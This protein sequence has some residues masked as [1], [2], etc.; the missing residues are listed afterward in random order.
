MRKIENLRELQLVNVFIYKELAEFCERNGLKVYL[1]GGS[2]IGAVRHKGFIPWDD[3]LDVC[4]SRKDYNKMLKISKGRISE[5]CSV[6]D[7]AK[8]K[9]FKGYISLVSYDKSKIVSKQYKQRENAKISVSVFVYDGVP[10][11]IAV[12]FFYYLHMYFLRAEHALCRSDFDHVNSKLAKIVGPI[13]SVFYKPKDVYRYKKKILKLQKKYPYEKSKYVAPNSDTNAW[14]EVFSRRS[15]EKT[16]KLDYEGV[17]CDAFCY[18]DEHLR[19]YYGDYMQF[20]PVEARVPKH[21]F[22]AWI[23]KSFDFNE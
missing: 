8:N 9:D 7:P 20:P 11:N 23:D 5:N 10:S 22:D 16:V 4:M 12:R 3:D 6:V 15:F 18:Y 21:S 2:L 17:K 1:L 14:L 19:K 13:L